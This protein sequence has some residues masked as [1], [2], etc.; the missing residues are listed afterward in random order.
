MRKTTNLPIRKPVVY[1]M[2]L[3]MSSE[4]ASPWFQ[5]LSLQVACLQPGL[6]LVCDHRDANLDGE[7]SP[8][9]SLNF[10]GVDYE[11]GTRRALA[12]FRNLVRV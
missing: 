10:V 4:R 3:E 7:A 11:F 1:R 8:L 12:I 6:T 9:G 2:T 5:V